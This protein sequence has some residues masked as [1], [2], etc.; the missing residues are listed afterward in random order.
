MNAIFHKDILINKIESIRNKIIHNGALDTNLK[1]YELI[2]GKKCI[3]K[4][5]LFT[6]NSNY[7]SVPRDFKEYFRMYK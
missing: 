1:V 5:I 4:F 7:S 6:V 3:E 2:E